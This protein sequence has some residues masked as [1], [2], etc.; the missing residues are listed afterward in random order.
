MTDWQKEMEK[1][2]LTRESRLNEGKIIALQKWNEHNVDRVVF[3]FTCGGDNMGDTSIEIYDKEDKII[4]VEEIDTY[5]DDVIYDKVD[6]YVNSDGHYLGESGEVIIT[7]SDDEEDEF[8]FSKCSEEEWC[9]HEPFIEKLNLTDEEVDF[10]D[11]YVTDFNG[12]S[13]ED[14]N[15]NY[16]VD[17]IQTDELVEVE[18]KLIEKIDEFFIDYEPDL[19]NMTD[20]ATI[21]INSVTLDKENKTIDVDMSFEHYVYRS[22]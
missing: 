20:W 4:N 17:F 2:R 15:I 18:K 1:Q 13:N 7:L 6:F 22:E 8:E 16:K 10:I 5:I 9:E 14:L 19:D 21:E 11:K 12:N 3:T